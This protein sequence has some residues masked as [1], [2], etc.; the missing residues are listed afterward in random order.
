MPKVCRKHKKEFYGL[1]C[2]ICTAP[3][4]IKHPDEDQV[5]FKKETT[6]PQYACNNAV[7]Q[8]IGYHTAECL[9]KNQGQ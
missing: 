7:C 9:A 5:P 3:P 1:R 8:V 2:P 4:V 6:P